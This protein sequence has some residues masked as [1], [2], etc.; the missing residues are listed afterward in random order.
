ATGLTA[1]LPKKGRTHSPGNGGHPQ[2]RRITVSPA[3]RALGQ[4]FVGH[5]CPLLLFAL[6]TLGI[7]IGPSIARAQQLDLSWSDNSGGQAGFII[8]RAPGST[9][10]YAQI[11]QLSPGVTSYTDTGVS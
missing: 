8:Q 3:R 11:A 2:F 10:T 6:V 9:G 4:G 1:G 5:T 7:V